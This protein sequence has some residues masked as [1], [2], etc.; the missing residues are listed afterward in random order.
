[1]NRHTSCALL[2]TSLWRQYRRPFRIT[3]PRI[4]G[5][6]SIPCMG[7]SV[8]QPWAL[9]LCRASWSILWF[10]ACLRLLE[11]SPNHWPSTAWCM[12]RPILSHF[13]HFQNRLRHQNPTCFLR[14][15]PCPTS[16]LPPSILSLV[17]SKA[18]LYPFY[19]YYYLLFIIKV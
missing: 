1:M 7:T 8:T 16:W 19:L 4:Q 2:N 6:Q 12:S 10:P 15:D 9:L 3:F 18:F 17:T 11:S 13:P 14:K 5:C